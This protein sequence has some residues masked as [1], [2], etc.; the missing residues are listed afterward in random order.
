LLSITTNE[1]EHR[2]P[3][4]NKREANIKNSAFNKNSKTQRMSS[5][6]STTT[7]LN[8][9]HLRCC[10]SYHNKILM[11]AAKGQRVLVVIASYL[12]RH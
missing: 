2:A 11:K 8:F 10:S 5:R 3:N 9:I 7:K 12:L 1:K 4:N 6:K